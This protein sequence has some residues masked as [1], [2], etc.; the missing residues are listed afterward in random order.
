MLATIEQERTCSGD[1]PN[2]YNSKTPV[3]ECGSAEVLR[4]A[5]PGD[6]QL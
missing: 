3:A 1:A 5:D 6:D 4:V 2:R